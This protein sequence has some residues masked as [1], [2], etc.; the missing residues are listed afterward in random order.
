MGSDH[1]CSFDEAFDRQGTVFGQ[2]EF[3]GCRCPISVHNPMM[4]ESEQPTAVAVMAPRFVRLYR[5]SGA[6]C[7]FDSRGTTIRAVSAKP[8][9]RR[10]PARFGRFASRGR[11]EC[12]VLDRHYS[13]GSRSWRSSTA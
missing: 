7:C 3:L 6:N 5:Q 12:R 8:E 11:T 2:P 4:P 13:M 9:P 10:T 1:R